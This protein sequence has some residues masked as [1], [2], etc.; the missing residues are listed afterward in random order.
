[1]VVATF[2]PDRPLGGKRVT[3]EGDVLSIEGAVTLT[4]LQVAEFDDKSELT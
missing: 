3:F 4:P 1:M 2:S